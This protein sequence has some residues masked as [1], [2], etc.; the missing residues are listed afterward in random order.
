MTR[1][2]FDRFAKDYLTELLSPLGE[3]ETSQ[4]V[5]AEVRQIDVR[6]TPTAVSVSPEFIQQLGLLGQ[7][8]THPALLE[9]YR[10]PPTVSE[11][12]SCLTKQFDVC[13]ELERRAKREATR[14]DSEDYPML[15][16]LTPTLSDAQLEGWGASAKLKEGWLPGVYFL[17]PF[18]RTAIIRNNPFIPHSLEEG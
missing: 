3:V 1:F 8:A 16:I 10:N 7:I 14:M 15:W 5:P 4:D 6:F 13:A 17:A 18:L 2:L 9:P 12:R 11:V